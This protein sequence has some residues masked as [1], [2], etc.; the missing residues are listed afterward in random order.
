MTMNEGLFHEDTLNLISDI[1]Q[2]FIFSNQEYKNYVL[3]I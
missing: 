2:V 1:V 3:M